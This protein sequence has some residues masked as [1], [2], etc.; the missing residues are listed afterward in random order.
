MQSKTSSS[1]PRD[2]SAVQSEAGLKKS[3]A[4]GWF[5][6]ALFRKNLTR[7]WPLWTLYAVIWLIMV[8]LV[9]MLTL[10]AKS[11]LATA[12]ERAVQAA[13][14]L[15]DT[16]ATGGLI[17]GAAF[18]C[19][20]A[21]ALFSYLCSARA[22]GMIHSFPIR[23]DSLFWTNYL[24]GAAVFVG[25]DL[26]TLLL[27]AAIQAANGALDWGNLAAW[28]ACSAGMMLFFYSFA[29]FCAMFT[30]QILAIPAFYAILNIL[31]L[32]IN[33]L[34]QNLASAFY[35]GYTSS[36]PAWVV[37]L[38]PAYALSSR[39]S[40]NGVWD[41][42]RYLYTRWL[43][44]G[45]PVVGVYAAAGVVF[46]LLA[47][48]V[49]IRRRSETAGDT[50]SIS[51]AKPIFSFGMALCFALSLGQGL[52]FLVWQSFRSSGDNSLPAVV[53]CMVVLG[54]VGYFAAEMLLNKSF[55]VLRSHWKNALAVTAVLIALGVGLGLDLTGAVARVPAANDISSVQMDISGWNS[56]SAEITDP[57]LIDSVC[58]AHQALIGEKE[59]Q[60]DRGQ[61]SGT[62]YWYAYVKLS[63]LLKNGAT[64]I[65]NYNIAYNKADLEKPESAV[66]ILSGIVAA[67]KVQRAN[68]FQSVDP[69]KITGGEMGY[70]DSDGSYQYKDF[71]EGAAR[72][73]YAALCEDID[74]GRV[75]VSQF[76]Q[77]AW[78][79][80]GYANNLAFYY[81]SEDGSNAGTSIQ[82]TDDYTALIAALK[83][84]GVVTASTPLEKQAEVNTS[85]D[86]TDT[87][88]A[89]PAAA[90]SAASVEG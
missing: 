87:E 45:L 44:S 40:V 43:I 32:G 29:C 2:N 36:T 76:D 86:D 3:R 85:A 65:R 56:F 38:T 41:Q 11:N 19:L 6:P 5:N 70:L 53:F 48:A 14:T 47:L 27:T 61:A 80:N 72:E 49:C 15:L 77:A 33:F 57:A 64:V 84:T 8:P 21:M 16:A 66:S 55:R 51:W 24:S 69:K 68:L 59:E 25:T 7:F 90:A 60:Q 12:S 71:G 42:S 88:S 67:P 73:I 75:G 83:K 58:Q 62:D 18:G 1:E 50:V 63:Y 23:R 89:V 13:E 52:Y 39:V 74:A 4:P 46:A 9:Q 35:Y 20:F 54:L 37:W 81:D 28:F 34:V 26:V 78:D 17:M 82:F 79:K 10:T 30:G 31:V 22:V